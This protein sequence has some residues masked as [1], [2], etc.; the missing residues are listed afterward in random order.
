MST[1]TLTL[2]A[3]TDN[4][5]PSNLFIRRTWSKHVSPMSAPGPSLLLSSAHPPHYGRLIT[6]GHPPASSRLSTPSM[7]RSNAA[8]VPPPASSEDIAPSQYMPGADPGGLAEPPLS[9]YVSRELYLN[10]IFGLPSIYI[11]LL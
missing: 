6:S 4:Y 10:C 8:P 1:A 9:P 11:Y 5:L 7:R 2:P 3:I